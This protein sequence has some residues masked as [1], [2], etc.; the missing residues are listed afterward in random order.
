[1]IYKFFKQQTI[2][3]TLGN[4]EI[5]SGV[6]RH[7]PCPWVKYDLVGDMRGVIKVDCIPSIKLLDYCEHP[8]GSENTELIGV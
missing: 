4:L 8:R 2:C 1:M 6:K 5:I 7:D 3:P